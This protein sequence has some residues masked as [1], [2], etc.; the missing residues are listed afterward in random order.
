MKRYSFVLAI[1]LIASCFSIVQAKDLKPKQSPKHVV[2]IAFDGLS[3]EGVRNHPMPNMNRLMNG[4][5]YT[6][7][8]RSILPSSS[9]PNWASMFTSVGPELHGYTTWGSKTPEIPPYITNRY[10]RFPGFYGLFR[11]ARRNAECGYIYEWEGMRY[12]VDSLAIDYFVH[13]PM[14]DR[15]PDGAASIAVNYIKEKKP[16]YCA[17]IFEEPDH[18]GHTYG[19]CSEEYYKKLD[20]LD[21]YLGMVVKAIE[22]AGI[23]DDTVIIVSADH[24]GKGKE[25]GGKS[26]NEM[27]TPLVFYGKGVKQGFDITE[28]TM[29]ID[30]PATEAW[31]FGIQLHEA[32]LG[33]PVTSAF[34]TK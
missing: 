28:S 18:T 17:V 4:G 20:Q 1:C 7:H 5:A 22:D 6:L 21:V 30:I 9:A 16:Q 15:Y 29:V 32:W 3:A 34:F 14:C 27:E 13:T 11:D 10:G 24:G 23:I 19:W 2:L 26:L 33:N 12:L 25:H 31:L 8:N